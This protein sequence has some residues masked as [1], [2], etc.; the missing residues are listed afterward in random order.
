MGNNI[1]DI[2]DDFQNDEKQENEKKDNSKPTTDSL[3]ISFKYPTNE[4][5]PVILADNIYLQKNSK[6]GK[7]HSRPKD[8]NEEDNILENNKKMK[9]EDDEELKKEK[10]DKIGEDE[11]NKLDIDNNDNKLD[12]VN[13]DN[14]L[15]IDNE[16]NKLDIDDEKNKL[17]IDNQNNKIDIDNENN[18][19]DIDNDI[20]KVLELQKEKSIEIEII[21]QKKEKKLKVESNA[22]IK[23]SDD[24]T[25][26]GED[27]QNVIGD[28]LQN[29]IEILT[30]IKS[31]IDDETV[32]L[33]S[34]ESLEDADLDLDP[35]A[36]IGSELPPVE[37]EA[38]V[39]L[40]ELPDDFDMGP[41]SFDDEIARER[42]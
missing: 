11:N 10:V 24:S 28:K 23:Y 35:T 3:N 30:D 8:S 14:K 1:S 16:N 7:K 4:N 19:L 2:E 26:S 5:Q 21:E 9:K 41:E 37:D 42:K 29:A 33:A 12:K 27:I 32:K 34:G 39:E 36:E 18:K 40:G 31:S 25:H 13:K 22:R 17:D 20:K 6:L 15:D 38:D